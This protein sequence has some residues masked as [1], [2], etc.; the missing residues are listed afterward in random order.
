M[1]L[2]TSEIDQPSNGGSSSNNSRNVVAIT[3]A[4]MIFILLSLLFIFNSIHFFSSAK[5]CSI[6]FSLFY[7][8]VPDF[9]RFCN[10]ARKTFK[11]CVQINKC[12][13]VEILNSSSIEQLVAWQLFIPI[14]FSI[15]IM[16]K[17]SRTKFRLFGCSYL[18]CQLKCLQLFTYAIENFY[19]NKFELW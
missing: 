2:C 18:I 1:C 9:S 14:P 11:L 4:A 13:S 15:F 10:A 8:T 19:F 16:N 17:N 7:C 12:D 3:T 5:C 6:Y